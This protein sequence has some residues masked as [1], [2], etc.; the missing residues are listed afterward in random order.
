MGLHKPIDDILV[1]LFF[2]PSML[3]MLQLYIISP[4]YRLRLRQPKYISHK[5]FH[6]LK[7][8]SQKIHPDLRKRNP[9]MLSCP[10]K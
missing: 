4:K 2:I 5:E 8:G 3:I 9:E 6:I 10:F 1:A 7:G